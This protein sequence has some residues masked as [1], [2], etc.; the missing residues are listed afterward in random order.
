MLHR[1]TGYV[2]NQNRSKIYEFDIDHQKGFVVDF[3][4]SIKCDYY[5]NVYDKKVMRWIDGS[6]MQA[7][8]EVDV[9][10][11]GE[12]FRLKRVVNSQVEY[13]FYEVYKN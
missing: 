5:L 9:Y 1:G 8:Y 10:K 3:S 2:L 7:D 12:Y 13:F 6:G 11:V 4:T